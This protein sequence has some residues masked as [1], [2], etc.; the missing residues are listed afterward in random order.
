MRRLLDF[1]KNRVEVEPDDIPEGDLYFL[2]DGGR[3]GNQ[4]ELLK[5]FQGQQKSVK[6]FLLWRDEDS[7]TQRLQR[8]KGGIGSCRQWEQLHVVSRSPPAVLPM[9]FQN[10]KSSTAGT[11][12]GPI[13][14]PD[15]I[16]CCQ[17]T[18]VQNKEIFTNA[19][20]IPVGGTLDSEDCADSQRAKPRDKTTVEP[21]FFHA[22]PQ[23]FMKSS[24]PQSPWPLCW[25]S[26]QETAHSPSV[27]TSVGWSMW[28][29]CSV[30][31]TKRC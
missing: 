21:V 4:A 11:M 1:A 22:L 14:L 12:M 6:T 7:L 9:K 24:F 23:S 13:V 10:F 26:R 18:W 15:Y 2:F 3:A 27:P 19:N 16:T 30:T 17:A 25:T 31:R 20:L 8:V 5:P 28:A 29:W